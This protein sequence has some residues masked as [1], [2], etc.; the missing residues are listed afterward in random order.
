MYLALGGKAISAAGPIEGLVYQAQRVLDFNTNKSFGSK[1]NLI[2]T[3][4]LSQLCSHK[5][6]RIHV[7]LHVE[8][9]ILNAF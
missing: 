2:A 9:R 6:A 1:I 8:N 4:V 3:S 7:T 5:Q